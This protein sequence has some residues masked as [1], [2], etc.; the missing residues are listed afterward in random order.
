MRSSCHAEAGFRWAEVV[1]MQ[2]GTFFNP[3]GAQELKMQVYK[4][5]K[6]KNRRLEEHVG[7]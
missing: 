2:Q 4:S 5:G 3:M 6:S 1:R 7:T